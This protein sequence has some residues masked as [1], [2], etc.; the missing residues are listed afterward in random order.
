[1]ILRDDEKPCED[2]FERLALEEPERL[3][4]LCE[5]DELEPTMLTFAA[6]ALGMVLSRELAVPVLLRLMRHEHRMV[7]EG[8]IRGLFHEDDGEDVVAALK[9]LAEKDP[10]PAVREV[11]SGRLTALYDS[12]LSIQY[13]IEIEEQRERQA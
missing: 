5:S 7:R 9:E 8:A 6:E 13:A 2:P 4:A 10:S 1:M 3:I 12:L 11:A